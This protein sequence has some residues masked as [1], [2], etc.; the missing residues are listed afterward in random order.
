MAYTLQ[1]I[2]AP[3]S[4]FEGKTFGGSM[5]ISLAQN[6]CILPF[7]NEFLCQQKL[8]ANPLMDGDTE[9]TFQTIREF[10]AQT[11]P[12]DRIAYIEAE[13]F[14]GSGTQGHVVFEKGKIISEIQIHNKAINEAL[15][16]LGVSVSGHDDEFA[17]LN[18]GKH[19]NTE[20][21][22]SVRH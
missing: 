10:C 8:P 2:I 9:N 12:Q 19:R 1:A 14:G 20:N 17:A 15:K 4:A 18:L 5:P 3:S 22:L 21:W 11:F 13:F 16:F 6:F 7:T